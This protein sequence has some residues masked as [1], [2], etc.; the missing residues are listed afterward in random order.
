MRAATAITDPA[1]RA[2]W[3]GVLVDHGHEVSAANADYD[4]WSRLEQ[5]SFD[6]LV[7]ELAPGSTDVLDLCRRLRRD[8]PEPRPSVLVLVHPDRAAEMV[9]ALKAGADDVL[10]GLPDR[11][12]A[13]THLASLERRRQAA[14]TSSSL[15]ELI[16]RLQAAAGDLAAQ[17]D[18]TAARPDAGA[19]GVEGELRIARNRAIELVAALDRARAAGSRRP[20]RRATILLIDDDASVRL[21]LR[22]ALEHTGFEVLEASDGP[23]GLEVFI[24]H[25]DEIDAVVVDQQMP[26]MS[27]QQVVEELK[28]RYPT[29]PVIL[30]SGQAVSDVIDPA[31]AAQPD[32]FIRKPFELVELARTVRRFVEAA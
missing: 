4:G 25:Q 9:A 22:R 21:A 2:L 8:R 26:Q 20:T 32:A 5:S 29:I 23:Q 15:S 3:H 17:L 27:G 18:V 19:T 28:R 16:G 1:L 10:V 11:R 30:I 6:L 31:S 14:P 12:A 13:G 7:L 24:R